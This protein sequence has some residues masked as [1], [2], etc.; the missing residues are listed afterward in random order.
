MKDEY[1]SY[2]WT[3]NPA[4]GANSIKLFTAVICEFCVVLWERPNLPKLQSRVGS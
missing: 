2:L 4:T 3:S 1:H